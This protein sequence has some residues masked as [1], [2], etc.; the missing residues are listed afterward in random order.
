MQP[1]SPTFHGR[2]S[3][4]RNII[5]SGRGNEVAGG[6]SIFGNPLNRNPIARRSGSNVPSVDMPRTTYE[7]IRQRNEAILLELSQARKRQASPGHHGPPGCI[8]ISIPPKP[9]VVDDFGRLTGIV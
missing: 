8:P 2:V 7:M 3:I 9:P 4:N 6:T 1:H 5:P